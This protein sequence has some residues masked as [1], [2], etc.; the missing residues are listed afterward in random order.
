[1]KNLSE[2]TILAIVCGVVAIVFIVGMVALGI[3][4]ALM[5]G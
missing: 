3:I 1:M 5:G 2:D 4:Q